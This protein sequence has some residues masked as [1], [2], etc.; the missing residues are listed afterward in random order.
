[1]AII[2]PF[3]EEITKESYQLK[4]MHA[5]YNSKF[6][7]LTHGDVMGAFLSLGIKRSK[8]GD[9][10]V[11]E[12][13]IQ[14]IMTE[15]ISL[16]VSANLT[17]INNANITLDEKPLSAFIENEQQWV[18]KDTTVSSMRIDVIIKEIY[19]LSRKNATSFIKRKLVKV[20]F[21]I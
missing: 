13:L 20:N 15:E 14:I 6:I 18:E 7:H 5:T 21:K 16:F 10:F 3:F 17:K 11:Q 8:L 9:I 1:R 2:A 4:L 12:G 19:R